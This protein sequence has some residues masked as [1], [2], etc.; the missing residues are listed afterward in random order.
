MTAS[1]AQLLAQLR[2]LDESERIEAKRGQQFGKSMLETICAFANEPGLN[3]GYLLLGV[4]GD[5]Q[6][7]YRVEGVPDPDALLNDL[8]TSCASVFNVP[9]RVQAVTEFIEGQR[10]VVIQVP[11]ARPADKPIYFKKSAL[12]KAAWRRGPN[13]D[14]RCNEH[15]LELLYQQRAQVEFDRSVPPGARRDDIDPDAINDYRR[16]RSKMNPSAEEL[17]YSDDELLEALG[18]AVWQHGEL[19][20]TLA[21]IL[22]FGR[23]M[24]IRRLMPAHRVDYIRVTGKE[25]IEN[26]DERFTTLDMRDTLPRL[27]NRASAAVMDDLPSAFHLPQGSIRREDKPLIPAKVIREA[28]VNAVMHR[29]YRANQPVQVIRFSNRIEIRNPGYSLKPAEQLGQPGSAWRN[30]VVATVLHEIGYAETK[31]SGIRVM[32]RQME[33]AGLT[34]PVFESVRNEDRFMATLLFV[35]FLDA[36]AVEWLKHFRHWALSEEECRALLFVRETGRIT[37][38]DYRD[39]NRVDTLAA[40][41]QLTRL[42]DLSILQQVPR[43]AATYYVPGEHFPDSA[44]GAALLWDSQVGLP[45]EDEALPGNPGSLPPESRSLPPE[46]GSLP[47]ES[48]SL[49]PGSG[50]LPPESGSL[51]R[52]LLV[53]ELPEWLVSRLEA[54]GQRSRDKRRVREVLRALCAERPY[55]AAELALLLQ[56]NQEYLQKEYITPMRQEGE[57]VYRYQDDPNRPDQAYVTPDGPREAE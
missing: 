38:A 30:P 51:S 45:L 43:G 49:P 27:V 55:R 3:G 12:P 33:Q 7:H 24:A 14:Y 5:G 53:A 35:H 56:R 50:S 11:E 57:L 17:G 41:Q 8:Q 25:W 4:A 52:N 10:L 1:V 44:G 31:G 46:S 6:G 32:R 22:L 54:I 36:E 20:P 23:R 15:D 39:Q 16:D 40:S 18:A 21:G 28:I 42:R 26:P 34:P 2:L 29:N 9:L 13:G 19:T 47:P 48:G 37:N